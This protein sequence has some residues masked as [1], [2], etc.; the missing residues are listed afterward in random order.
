MLGR[1]SRVSSALSST[2]T[3]PSTSP[4]RR[5]TPVTT[6]AWSWSGWAL[7]ASPGTGV[8]GVRIRRQVAGVDRGRRP[9]CLRPERAKR[10]S[11]GERSERDDAFHG[12]PD[13]ME[14]QR[15]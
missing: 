13:V 11:G 1:T 2:D 15:R 10:E 4:R 3:P 8:G 6:I 14:D 5:R 9:A 12:D 7:A